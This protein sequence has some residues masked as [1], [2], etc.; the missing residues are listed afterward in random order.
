[1]TREGY[2]SYLLYLALQRHFSTDYDYFLYNGKVRA[3]KEA[4]EK[5]SDMYSFEKLN[6]IV[7]KEQHEDFFVS[8]FLDNP[9]EWIKNMSKSK[10]E[11]YKATYTNLPKKFK[12]DLE[13][14]KM[15]GPGKMIA[16]D[17]DIPQ[18]HQKVLD[19]TLSIETIILLDRLFP[20]IEKHVNTVDIS[21]VW[22]DY[23]RKLTKYK[24]F[25]EKKLNGNYNIYE[26]IARE[27]LL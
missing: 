9:K 18:I 10:L 21:F 24:P 7:P 26:D 23:K 5:R 16:V 25:V 11:Q 6:R 19:G 4:Y 20:F 27:I 3:S 2:Q 8:H 13:Y 14:I 15:V 1:M 22:P 17:R 12:E